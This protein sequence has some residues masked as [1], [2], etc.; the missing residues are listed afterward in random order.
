MSTP[1]RDRPVAAIDVGTNTALLLIA[2]GSPES[3]TPLLERATITRLGKGVDR[4]GR[5]DGAALDRTIECLA[6]YGDE[7]RARGV[8]HAAAVCTSA[9]RDAENGAELVARAEAALGCAVRVIGGEEEAA[10][11]FEGA[12]T[13]LGVDGAVTVFDVGGGS[14]EIIHG[15]ASAGAEG[16]RRLPGASV[17]LDVGSVRLTERHLSSDP[18]TAAEL[19]ATTAAARTALAGATP[20]PGTLVGVAGTVTTLAALHLGLVPYDGARVHGARLSLL[21]VER[22]SARLGSLAVAERAR[23]PGLD[24][25][26]ADVIVAGALLVA[27]LLRWSGREELIAS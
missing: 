16:S 12:L 7:L 25:K 3:P 2:G 23:L 9:A 14:T 20:R 24:P 1:G 13:G 18:P 10:L 6:G 19:A 5:L 26:R 21:D 22:W 11:T 8:T 27:E 4:T 15:T 17:S